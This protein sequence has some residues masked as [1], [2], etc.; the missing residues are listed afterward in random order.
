MDLH[1][2]V[3]MTILDKL[4]KGIG[5]DLKKEVVL[6]DDYIKS[7]SIKCRDGNQPAKALSGGNQQKVVIANGWLRSRRSDHGRADQ[8]Y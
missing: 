3:G 4:K 2:N 6:M 8:R 7:L 5:L 1:T